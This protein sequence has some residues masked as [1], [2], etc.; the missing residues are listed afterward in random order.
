VS[1][2]GTGLGTVPP[3]RPED[4]PVSWRRSLGRVLA[5]PTANLDLAYQ[6]V[7]DLQRGVVVGY[8]ALARIAGPPSAPPDR[9]FA[10]AAEEGLAARLEAVVLERA[11]P[12]RAALPPD[13][14]LSVN[15]NPNLVLDRT[16][17]GVLGEAGELPGVVLE[18]TEHDR[19]DDYGLL[20]RALTRL[21]SSGVNIAMD[22]AGAG[23]AGLSSLLAL[24]PD[25][26]KLDRSLIAGIDV[27]PVKQELVELLGSMVG[28]MDAWVLAE[29]VE[30]VE[31]LE[32]LIRIGVPL[33]QGYLL[34]RPAPDRRD[35]D[36][37]TARRIRQLAGAWGEGDAV[38]PLVETVGT[39][40]VGSVDEA[41][42]RF[43]SDGGLEVVP[44]LDRWERPVALHRR[45][46]A[47]AGH[48]PVPAVLRVQAAEPV[49]AVARRAMG[50]PRASRFD[51]LLCIDGLG[52]YTGVVRVERLLEA[53]AG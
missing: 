9:W 4:A 17:Q 21:R 28:R 53:L 3:A 27:D 47:L 23:Y 1:V 18:L 42:A 48:G 19:I 2:R 40:R 41:V 8:E 16:V 5:D 44:V 25:L 10:A 12:T 26:V 33:G 14:F 32:V 15:L 49:A 36:E 45:A 35:L 22:D 6:P 38:A 7:V 30:R 52:R 31:E 51:P 20:R 34:G 24:R 13:C 37:G 50:R 29:G 43:Q 11:L 46:D 39:V